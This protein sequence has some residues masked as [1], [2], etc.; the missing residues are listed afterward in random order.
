[1]LTRRI[2]VLCIF[3]FASILF[4]SPRADAEIKPGIRVGAYFDAGGFFV[5]GEILA[6]IKSRWYLNPNVEYV[7]ADGG[8]ILSLNFDVHYDL[9]T[10]SKDFFVW[11]GGGLAVL[12][13]DPDNPRADGETDPGLNLLMGIGFPV[14]HDNVFYIQPKAILSDNS[15]FSLAFGFR[16]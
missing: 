15:D 7:F 14:G 10:S 4:F 5:G 2:A 3:L 9:R 12:H 11:V 6:K 13:F 1:M 16:F 8:D